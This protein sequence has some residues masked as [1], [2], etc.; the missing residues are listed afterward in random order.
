MIIIVN[1]PIYFKFPLSSR[2]NNCICQ[3]NSFVWNVLSFL[4]KLINWYIKEPVS[5]YKSNNF[6]DIK[7]K[8][9]VLFWKIFQ[10]LKLLTNSHNKNNE[11][12]YSQDQPQL[13]VNISLKAQSPFLYFLCGIRLYCWKML[14]KAML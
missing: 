2:I 10:N 13:L 1:E 6:K 3:L 11:K 5:K 4:N 14:I 8:I 12:M 9:I 7:F